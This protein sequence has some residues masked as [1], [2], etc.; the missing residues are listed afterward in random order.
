MK[1]RRILLTLF[2][3]ACSCTLWIAINLNN[4]FQSKI[5][6]PLEI[7]RLPANLAIATPLPKTI[8][9][10][11]QGT[12][13]Q[14]FKVTLSP[15]LNLKVD[16]ND[17]HKSESIVISKKMQEYSNLPSGVRIIESYPEKI[18]LRL[19]EKITR[20]V[21]IRPVIDIS[22]REGFGI[23]GSI[24][25]VPESI[26]ITGA[27]SLISSF[28][29]WSTT[30]VTM[31]DVNTPVNITSTLHDTLHYEVEHSITSA[32]IQFDVQPIAE[33]TIEEV[34]IEIIQVPTNKHVVLIPPKISIIIRSGVNSIAGLTEKDFHVFVDYRT[35]LLDTSGSI[36]PTVNGPDKIKIV[37]QRPELIQYVI[38]K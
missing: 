22:Y 38:R 8:S 15:S 30:L 31:K 14:I 21:P 37:L 29:G 7:D 23:V 16:F 17:F 3:I 9:M 11:I 32:N 25:A 36:R 13:W 10:K 27:R 5:V 28:K 26:S 35:I 33:R 20:R 1:N 2:S 6:I 19:E 12:G 24:T 18:E 4:Q 34:P